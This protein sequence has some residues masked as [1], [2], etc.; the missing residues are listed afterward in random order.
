MTAAKSAYM[1]SFPKFTVSC[2]A[3]SH[4]GASPNEMRSV[5]GSGGSLRMFKTWRRACDG[6][7]VTV[8]T[9]YVSE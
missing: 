9:V 3:N 5:V 6:V 4:M 2:S 7:R 8:E 1:T